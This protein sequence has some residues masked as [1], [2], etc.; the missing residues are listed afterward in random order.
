[1]RVPEQMRR[2]G[3]TLAVVLCASLLA[4]CIGPGLEPPLGP[5][6][7][8]NAAGSGATATGNNDKPGPGVPAGNP[9]ATTPP[10]TT[11]AP[12]TP[13]MPGADGAPMKPG[14]EVDAGTDDS[15]VTP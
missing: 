1:M 7:A 3:R 2:A 5:M 15:G 4:A 14:R 13:T 12:V 11:T 8:Q 6:T 10:P 9:P